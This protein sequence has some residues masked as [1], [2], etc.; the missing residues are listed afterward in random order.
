MIKSGKFLTYLGATI[1]VAGSATLAEAHR[2]GGRIA[3]HHGGHYPMQGDRHHHRRR[4]NGNRYEHIDHHHMRSRHDHLDRGR[5][6][7]SDE[8]LPRDASKR[9]RADEI[10]PRDAS[11]RRRADE[12]M[13]QRRLRSARP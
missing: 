1:L 6:G 4:M 12:I 8:I 10:M 7:R 2:G 9:R 11:N 5:V 3:W 13:P